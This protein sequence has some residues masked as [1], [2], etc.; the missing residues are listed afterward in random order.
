ML[1]VSAIKSVT[2]REP[3]FWSQPQEYDRRGAGHRFFQYPAM[4]LPVVQRK[5][6][7]LVKLAA[8]HTKTLL[9]PFMG[10]GTALGAGMLN[11][12]DCYGQD[13]NPMSILLSKVKVGAFTEDAFKKAAKA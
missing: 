7:E 13:I 2:E 10:S 11:G 12:L 8:P 5:L 1:L 4:M 6:V 3:N 9:D